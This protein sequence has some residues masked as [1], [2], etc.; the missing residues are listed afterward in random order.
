MVD[1]GS[2]LVRVFAT[3]K[4]QVIRIPDHTADRHLLPKK[5]RVI[6]EVNPFDWVV[7]TSSR[8]EHLDPFRSL[9]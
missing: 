5:I 6:S 2:Y 8:S 7:L 1:K 9:K 3:E 4:D